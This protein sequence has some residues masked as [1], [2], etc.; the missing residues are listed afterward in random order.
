MKSSIFLALTLACALPARAG[1]DAVFAA[2][3]ND[4]FRFLKTAEGFYD[5]DTL[6]R[7]GGVLAR[8]GS[9]PKLQGP[10]GMHC[11]GSYISR[12]GHILT[13][14]HCVEEAMSR[15]AHETAAPLRLTDHGK[16]ATFYDSAP[17]DLSVDGSPLVLL[18]AGRGY[19]Y[20]LPFHDL[21]DFSGLE[22]RPEL[23]P[24]LAE[25][26]A[27]GD[28]AIVKAEN[29]TNAPCAPAEVRAVPPGEP[30]WTVGYPAEARRPRAPGSLGA[31]QHVTYGEAVADMRSSGWLKKMS[32]VSRENAY[33]VHGPG[34]ASGALILMNADGFSG[35]SGSPIFDSQGRIVGV[36]AGGGNTRDEFLENSA[37]GPSL[38]KIFGALRAAGADP[39]LYFSCPLPAPN[40]I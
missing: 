32:P 24:R 1:S 36:L 12:Q 28:W 30:L 14:A 19:A 26:G 16:D 17:T 39:A 25:L 38:V 11:S 7:R 10:S 5:R 21:L 22:G 33:R 4:G 29:A 40:G 2:S 15:A 27:G 9:A 18:A 6:P 34:V 20:L 37:W 13:N 23:F 31:S 3:L 35:M 8:L